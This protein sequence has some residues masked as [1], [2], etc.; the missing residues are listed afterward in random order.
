MR[1]RG[2]RSLPFIAALSLFSTCQSAP[3]SPSAPRRVVL[4][5]LDG[6]GADELRRLWRQGVL[7]EGGFARFFRD[8]QVAERLVNVNPTLTAPNHISL[9]TGYPPDRTGIVGNTI[10]LPGAPFT[11]TVRGFD[12]TIET[13]TLWEAARRQ[14][15]RVAVTT[16]PGADNKNERRRADW[17]MV[18]VNDP[19]RPAQLV[20]LDQRQWS[21][22]GDAGMRVR[23]EL[24]R[25][26]PEAQT[27]H[28]R[29]TSGGTLT[30]QGRPLALNAWREIPCRLHGREAVCPVKLLEASPDLRRVRI[31]FNGVYPLEA[32]PADFAADLARRELYWPGEPD[33]ENEIDLATWTEQAE[34]FARFFGDSLLA[35]SERPGWDLL[36]G[37]IPVIDEADHELTLVDPRQPGFSPQRR[38]QLERARHRVWKAVDRELARLL[39]SLDLESTVVV[40]VSDHGMAPIHTAIDPNVLLRREGLLA[41]DAGGNVLAKGTVAH[42]VGSGGISHVWVA[43]GR[44]AL[45]P[46]LRELFAGWTVDGERPVERIVAREEAADLQLNHPNSG[47]LILIVRP[48]FSAHGGLLDEDVPAAPTTVYG[49]HG[50]LNT[51]PAMHGIFLSLGGGVSKGST[52]PVRTTEVAGR[53]AGWL[54]I[55]KPRPRPVVD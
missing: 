52:G 48:G 18:Y 21:S 33:D 12:H 46:R 15:K 22:A 55:E 16:F 11:R 29:V 36:M 26:R 47:D 13:E 3:P 41:A 51:Q 10:Q 31:Y 28:V 50:Y 23:L 39:G 27:F 2:F 49:M 19:G 9:A 40:V 14:G 42:A 30:I 25:G 34:R 4:L 38:A 53:V 54:G 32:Y 6:A 44:R 43:P 24:S 5:S 37:Y 8:G 35:A 17:G 7:S 1:R 45:L 20:T